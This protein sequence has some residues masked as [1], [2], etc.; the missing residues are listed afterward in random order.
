M[1]S[2][3]PAM[4]RQPLCGPSLLPLLVLSPLCSLPLP[5]TQLTACCQILAAC[6]S[7]FVNELSATHHRTF[8]ISL[9]G[10]LS[11]LCVFS[12]LQICLGLLLPTYSTAGNEEQRMQLHCYAVG[13]CFPHCMLDS[14]EIVRLIGSLLR[15]LFTMMLQ[16]MCMQKSTIRLFLLVIKRA[17]DGFLPASESPP[18][19]YPGSLYLLIKGSIHQGCVCNSSPWVGWRGASIQL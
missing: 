5:C 19:T 18:P 11:A 4:P 17:R 6:C 8:T 16:A 15:V 3:A 14:N 13:Q 9:R 1:W 2:Q 7:V 12:V 10:I